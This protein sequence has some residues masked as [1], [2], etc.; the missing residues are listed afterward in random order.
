M[1]KTYLSIF[2]SRTLIFMVFTSAM[3]IV[4]GCASPS[5]HD[6]KTTQPSRVSTQQNSTRTKE[7]IL[8]NTYYVQ[9]FSSG[10]TSFSFTDSPS[11]SSVVDPNAERK[12]KGD[13]FVQF[14]ANYLSNHGLTPSSS[15]Q[16]QYFVE[17]HDQPFRRDLKDLQPDET[18]YQAKWQVVV[19]K[20]KRVE[21]YIDSEEDLSAILDSLLMDKA[22]EPGKGTAITK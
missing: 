17:I 10:Y 2:V 18:P 11:G 9:P 13:K 3:I 22:V 19:S 15:S 7:N 4:F 12:V 16:A 21:R 8:P 6:L 14:V 5:T 20:P 1:E